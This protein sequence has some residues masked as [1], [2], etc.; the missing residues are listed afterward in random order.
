VTWIETKIE[1]RRD[2]APGLM[3][4]TLDV[5][6][7]PFVPGQ[8]VNLGLDRGGERIKRSYSLASA[9]GAP[10]EVY[11]SLVPGG[12]L[13][14]ALFELVPGDRLWVDDRALGFFTLEHVPP[15]EHAWLLATGTGLGPF[16][17]MLR[18]PSIW[19]R[20]A[21]IVLV[22]GVR[23]VSHLGYAQ[24]LEHLA[25]ARGGQ[26]VYLPLVT[27]EAP[28][29]GGLAGRLPAL[30]E[31]GAL[32]RRVGLEFAASTDHVL[33]CGNPAMISESQAVLGARGLEK[34]RPRKPG[35]ITI[36]SYW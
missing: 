26:L 8:F 22:H 9:P 31:S 18:S 24:E 2:W 35:H 10:S 6:A 1:S 5:A 32:E 20:F 25:H 12:E 13:T 19:Q 21:R 7:A 3:S 17:A 33:L 15:A 36:E 11:L 30:I 23:Y 4:L 29:A 28:P 16:L 27:R 34:H 14:P